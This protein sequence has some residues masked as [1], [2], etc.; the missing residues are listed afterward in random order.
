MSESS[1]MPTYGRLKAVLSQQSLNIE[2][3][4][5]IL[6]PSRSILVDQDTILRINSDKTW[7]NMFVL[8]ESRESNLTIQINRRKLAFDFK[9]EW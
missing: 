4:G 6:F 7:L 9:T 8:S 5:Q 2:N 3:I 1:K